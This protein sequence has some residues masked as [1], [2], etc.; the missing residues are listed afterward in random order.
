MSAPRRER[1]ASR[2]F[3]NPISHVQTLRNISANDVEEHKITELRNNDYHHRTDTDYDF[4]TPS[5][6]S[7]AI[8]WDEDSDKY[9]ASASK[10]LGSQRAAGY[11]DPKE[12][13]A[14]YSTPNAAR[15]AAVNNASTEFT[16]KVK[17]GEFVKEGMDKPVRKGATVKIDSN[18]AK[19]K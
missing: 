7:G 9:E 12:M 19:G 6:T 5:G 1:N 4:K 14:T 10:K 16:R 8:R 3:K 18:P 2:V 17:S 13:Q 11:S 15:Q